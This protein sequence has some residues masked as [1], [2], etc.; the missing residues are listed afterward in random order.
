MTIASQH[1]RPTRHLPHIALLALLSIV[2]AAQPAA[3]T[4][5]TV[6]ERAVLE[7]QAEGVLYRGH[8]A[9]RVA[10][11]LAPL[12]GW[13]DVATVARQWS[14]GLSFADVRHN[15]DFAA[16]YGHW[17]GVAENV[18][19]RAIVPA[20]QQPTVADVEEAARGLLDQWW[21]SPG[22]RD[23]WMDPAYD[24][25]G[26]GVSVHREDLGDHGSWWVLAAT[27]NFRDWDGTGVDA[28]RAV[29]R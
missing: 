8:D 19:L 10:S 15:P 21:E 18:A 25:I 1:H 3:A 20:D 13:T 26:V 14:D 27:V 6:A 23:N 12:A 24:H 9:R 4:T 2:L 11:S 29:V 17:R 5:M 22:H 28:E 16:Q 7:R